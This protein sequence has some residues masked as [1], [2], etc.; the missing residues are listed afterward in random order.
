[1]KLKS[2]SIVNLPSFIFQIYD[3]ENLNIFKKIYVLLI[4]KL[5]QIVIKKLD[6]VA[7]CRVMN[8][9]FG[10]FS[11]IKF[12]KD[13]QIYFKNIDKQVKIYYPNKRIT[14]TLQK[15]T[16]NLFD[17]LFKTY[18][19][20]EID[21]SDGDTV[22]DCGANVGELNF[23][24][25]YKKINI[26]YIGIEPD[27]ETFLCLKKNKI[28]P[29]DTIHNF[30]LSDQ[31]GNRDLYLDGL[32]GNS[33]LEYFGIETKQTT[34]IKT[35]D[36]LDIKSKIKS[37]KVEAEGHEPEILKGSIS[38]FKNI[39]YI[40][41]DFGYER[42]LDQQSTIKSVNEILTKNNFSLINLSQYRLIGLYK[43][44]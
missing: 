38:S 42:G 18:C 3:V 4:G 28:R 40:S 31:L 15:N 16:L 29:E 11:Q 24:F 39:D 20:D 33:S 25:Y 7:F 22:V 6:N 9:L 34:E 30:A 44:N 14:R 36:S 19:L 35:L 27:L 12:E 37:F 5:S 23:S 21:F 41:V 43:H 1:M 26:N 32:G 10:K 2:S 17:T 8:L 13:S